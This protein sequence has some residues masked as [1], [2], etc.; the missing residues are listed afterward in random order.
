MGY[1]L[2]NIIF[3]T[4]LH[5]NFIMIELTQ[6]Y[7]HTKAVKKIKYINYNDKNFTILMK[8]HL[9]N[10]KRSCKLQRKNLFVTYIIYFMKQTSVYIWKDIYIPKEGIQFL[11]RIILVMVLGVVQGLLGSLSEYYSGTFQFILNSRV[12]LCA[13]LNKYVYKS[14]KEKTYVFIN[15]GIT[16]SF[17]R[18]NITAPII[19]CRY[20]LDTAMIY[21]FLDSI[22][23]IFL[24]NHSELYGLC[25]VFLTCL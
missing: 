8:Q 9:K 18:L 6:T 1:F 17:K 10:N 21:L 15:N 5:I 2:P 4:L 3:W 12:K 13:G 14:Y 22:P 24:W 19:R 7:V 23:N 20:T 25:E 11:V 16:S